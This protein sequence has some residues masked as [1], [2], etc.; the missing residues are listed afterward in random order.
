MLKN[1]KELNVW[2]KAY[3]LC[4]DIYKITRDFPRDE[5]FGLTSQIRRAAV[6]VPSNIAEGYG[7][8]TKGEYVQALYVAYGSNCELE[9]QILLSGDLGYAAGE[10]FEK[11]QEAIGDVE[12]MLKALIKSLESKPRSLEP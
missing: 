12:R 10:M 2:K 7:R 4:L 11:V 6:S 9:T 1:Y 5:R 8:K 3:Q